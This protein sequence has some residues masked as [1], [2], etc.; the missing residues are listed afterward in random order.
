MLEV[1]N[2]TKVYSGKGGVSVRALDDVSVVFP[3]TGMV[4]LLGKSGSGKSTLLNVAG[5]LDKPDGGEVI[6]K[7]KSSRDFSGSDFDSYRNTFIGFVFQEYNILNEFTIEQNIAL[8]LQ[9][10][11]KPNDKKAVAALLEQVD[12]AGYAKRKPNTLSGGQKQRVAIARALIKEPEII[13]ADEPTGALDSATGKQVLDTLKKLSEKK[14]VIVVSHDREFA[15]LYGDRIIELKD[16]KIISDVSKVYSSPSDLDGKRL[17]YKDAGGEDRSDAMNVAMLSDNTIA[18]RDAESLTDAEVRRIGEMLRA[19]KGEVIITADQKD[20]PGVKRACKINDNGNKESFRDTGPVEAQEYDGKK[21]KFIKSH[22]PLGH[23]IKMGASGLKS[24]PFRLIFTI[25]LAVAAFILFGV[26]STFMLYDPNYSVS[27]AMRDTAY[28]AATIGKEYMM[29]IKTYRVDDAGN[30]EFDYDYEN[31]IT[32]RFGASEVASRS[33]DGLDFAGVF[34]F[35]DYSYDNHE[36]ADLTLRDEDSYNTPT[37]PTGAQDYYFGETMRA[38]GFSDC[39]AE[40]MERNGFTLL[41]GTYPTSAEEVAL[42]AHL[43]E[44]FLLQESGD[45]KAYSTLIDKKIKFSFNSINNVFFTVK[46]IYN[47]GAIPDKYTALKGVTSS[48][49]AERINDKDKKTRKESFVDYLRNSFNLVVFVTPDF[50]EKYKDRIQNGGGYYMYVQ[51]E[52]YR[53]ITFQEYEMSGDI[54]DPYQQVYTEKTLKLFGNNVFTFYDNHDQA[55]TFS[56]SVSGIYLS[57]DS[58]DSFMTSKRNNAKQPLRQAID[59]YFNPLYTRYVPEAMAEYN[60][61]QADFYNKYGGDEEYDARLTIAKK[62]FPTYMYRNYLYRAAQNLVASEN[63]A[64]K[65][66]SFYEAYQIIYEYLDN[67]KE[68]ATIP[69]AETWSALES[70]VNQESESFRYGCLL[71]ILSNYPLYYDDIF[72]DTWSVIDGLK[73]GNYSAGQLA[74][75]KNAIN[76]YL[77]EKGLGAFDSAKPFAL[78]D[79]LFD[80]EIPEIDPS[81]LVYYYL[82]KNSQGGSLAVLGYFVSQSGSSNAAYFLT[83]SFMNAHASYEPYSGEYQVQVAESSYTVPADAKYNYL[84]TLTDN[85]KT[86]IASI[87]SAEEGTKISVMSSVYQELQNFLGMIEELEEIFLYVGLGVGVLAAFFLLNFISV[88]IAAKK[89]DIGI[90]RAVGARG[91]DVFKIFYAEAFIIAF[92]CFVLASIGSYIL[93]FFLNETMAEVVSMKLLNFGLVNIGLVF[94][95]S[96]AVS[97][98]ATFFPVFFAARKSPVEAIRAL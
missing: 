85:S 86:Q 19:Q 22:L 76:A 59:T 24:K 33:K 28:P 29:T 39:G 95:I 36:T 1:K 18:I 48:G 50:Y 69:S 91:S 6:V 17:E 65:T 4:F 80:I 58:Y 98:I 82:D 83:S 37:I 53:K 16:G 43:A 87:L 97:V 8:A 40:Y 71:E 93:C 60:E 26:A 78:S 5:G 72:E 10:Q 31:E 30:R 73:Y 25:L 9:L 68:D 45:L 23:A 20:L 74:E 94:G 44:P 63:E 2:L 47:V 96:I 46:G 70:V 13:M 42:P 51:S 67:W 11:S 56:E 84:V 75:A 57:K 52:T 15:E 34:N 12:L 49:V 21:T 79:N 81:E 61:M 62:Y 3:E 7:G 38:A 66:G 55:V 41:A 90:L 88:S 89:K 92:I 32:T 77:T 54:G 35:T 64:Y 27:E 14:L